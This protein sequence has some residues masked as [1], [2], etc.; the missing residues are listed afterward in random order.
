MEVGEMT[1][2]DESSLFSR[3]FVGL[4]LRVENGEEDFLSLSCTLWPL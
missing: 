1:L 4:A 3:I 2:E